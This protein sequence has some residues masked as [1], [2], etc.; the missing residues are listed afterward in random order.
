MPEDLPDKMGPPIYAPPPADQAVQILLVN[1]AVVL[2]GI[3]YANWVG[4]PIKPQDWKLLVDTLTLCLAPF[5]T[6]PRN[7]P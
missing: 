6:N 7:G 2:K 3:C 4:K 5:D 1:V